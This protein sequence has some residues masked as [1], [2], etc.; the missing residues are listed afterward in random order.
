MPKGSF[1]NDT[2]EK[3][4]ELGQ[5]TAK[6]TVKSVGQTFSPLK[7]LEQV[8]GVPT[9]NQTDKGAE[10]LK[11]EGQKKNS[12]TPLDFDKLQKNYQDQDKIK[13]ESLRNRLFQLVK[14]GE[15]KGLDRQKR[16]EEE[17]KRQVAYEEQEKNKKKEEQK[18]QEQSA[19][20]PRGKQRRSIFSH[21]K[22]AQRQ[23]AEVKPSAGK[24]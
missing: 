18:K 15:E 6:Q 17:K 10:R 11:N 12:S 1:L 20:I 9:L 21:K 13:T 23:Q 16:E 24:Q 4:V 3:L 2:F 14:S 7:I 19:E 8:T 5:S 22:V